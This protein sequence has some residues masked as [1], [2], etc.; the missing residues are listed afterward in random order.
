MNSL[1][2]LVRESKKR[3]ILEEVIK[4][5]KKRVLTK[6]MIQWMKAVFRSEILLQKRH[7]VRNIIT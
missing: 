3:E 1:K 4:S 5:Y 2:L 6:S 7:I